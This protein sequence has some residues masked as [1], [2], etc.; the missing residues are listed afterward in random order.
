M[1]FTLSLQELS[2]RA[3]RKNDLH[4]LPITMLC[5]L[6][7]C[8]INYNLKE[9][10]KNKHYDCFL[11]ASSVLLRQ[12]LERRQFRMLLGVDKAL[13]KK[14]PIDDLVNWDMS[15]IYSDRLISSLIVYAAGKNNIR[16]IRHMF[17]KYKL[18]KNKDLVDT[19]FFSSARRDNYHVVSMLM[20]DFNF[21]PTQ[22]VVQTAVKHNSLITLYHLVMLT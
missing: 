22:N 15:M 3:V 7:K 14:E 8:C 1:D 21:K 9:A 18:Y 2:R 19:L 4:R 16:F 11:A 6:K 10:V 17:L 12:P 5:T 13:Y 20:G